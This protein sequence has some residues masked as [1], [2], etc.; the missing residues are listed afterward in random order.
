[1]NAKFEKDVEEALTSF[2]SLSL[3]SSGGFDVCP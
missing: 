3:H 1:M 2:E